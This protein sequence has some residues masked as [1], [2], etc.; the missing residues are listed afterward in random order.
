MKKLLIVM[1]TAVVTSMIVAGC[2]STAGTRSEADAQYEKFKN[3]RPS[4]AIVNTGDQS[5]DGTAAASAKVY[6]AVVK[7]LDE[8]ITATN[9]N[10]PYLGFVNEV[11]ARMDADKNLT[12]EKAIAA[13][14]EE[15][16]KLDEGKPLENQEYPR[17][18]AGHQAVQALKPQNKLAELAQLAVETDKILDQTN[19]LSKSFKGFDPEM[20]KKVKSVKYVVEQAKFAGKAIDFLNYRFK[21]E[22]SF[23]NFM[24]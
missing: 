7:Y 18:I 9:D 11:Q 17:I 13:V 4:V 23:E 15:A 22:Q 20:L 21:Q 5:L 14:L 6:G 1:G 3:E 8:Y 16:K 24:K 2:A 10:R 12:E 19:G